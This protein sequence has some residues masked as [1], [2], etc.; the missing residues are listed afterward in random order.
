MAGGLGFAVV[1]FDWIKRN[2][3]EVSGCLACDPLALN[4]DG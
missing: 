3:W 4:E 1:P 2:R